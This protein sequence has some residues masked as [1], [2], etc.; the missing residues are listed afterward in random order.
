MANPVRRVGDYVDALLRD[1][2]PQ[3]LKPDPEE[4]AAL[5]QATR[6]SS[7]RTGSD[8]PQT[9]FV[10][11]LRHRLRRDMEGTAGLRRRWS[12]RAVLQGAGAAA[13]AIAAGVA[14]D[15][16]ASLVADSQPQAL[17]PNNA[18]W[19]AV[20]NVSEISYGSPLRFR[21]GAV[22]GFVFL[23][24]GQLRGISAVCTHQGCL[25][26][27]NATSSDL[28][29]P[30]HRSTFATSGAVVHHQLSPAPR[31]L[32]SIGVRQRGESIEVL[33]V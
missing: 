2:R 8:A 16:A 10:E 14:I 23:D 26:E 9:E 18:N 5:R 32:P 12:R 11:N 13:A 29:C 21:A 17:Q 24:K 31:P 33:V 6:M 15:R 22:E 4:L 20:G 25:L 28:E 3:R 19:V 7:L 27:Y 1:R 30:C